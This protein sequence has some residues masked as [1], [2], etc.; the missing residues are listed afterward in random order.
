MYLQTFGVWRYFQS[1]T[2]H[3]YQ[4]PNRTDTL[5]QNTSP[6]VTASTKNNL[7]PIRQSQN[8]HKTTLL[9]FLLNIKP[10]IKRSTRNNFGKILQTSLWNYVCCGYTLESS[11]RG[12]F[13][14]YPL[15]LNLLRPAK[16]YHKLILITVF[17]GK[18]THQRS[19]CYLRRIYLKKAILTTLL[20]LVWLHSDSCWI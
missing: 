13:E 5:F 4:R 11:L 8:W 9:S 1:Q 7:T 14:E 10:Q 20:L 15:H 17:L 16:E 18:E 12:D 6:S 19:L 3:T 2:G